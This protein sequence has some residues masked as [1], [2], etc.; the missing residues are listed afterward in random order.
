MALTEQ[1]AEDLITLIADNL[2]TG[3]A[4]HSA[5]GW[6]LPTVVRSRLSISDRTAFDGLVAATDPASVPALVAAGI[7]VAGIT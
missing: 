7:A 1:H 6:L 3:M 5:D 4:A 2:P